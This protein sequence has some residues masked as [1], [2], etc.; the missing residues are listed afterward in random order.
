MNKKFKK[1]FKEIENLLDEIMQ[2]AIKENDN[3]AKNRSCYL[4]EIMDVGEE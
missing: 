2:Q 3:D 1:K 4:L